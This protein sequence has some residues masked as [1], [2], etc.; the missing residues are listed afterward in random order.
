MRS[1]PTPYDTFAYLG[2]YLDNPVPYE[3][4]TPLIFEWLLRAFAALPGPVSWQEFWKS[5]GAKAN[6]FVHE[7]DNDPALDGRWAAWEEP[8]E[9]VYSILLHRYAGRLAGLGALGFA[10]A[11]PGRTVVL[12]TPIGDWLFGRAEEWKLPEIRKGVAVVGADFTVSLLEKSP[13]AEAELAGFA[14]AD[15]T[16]YRITRESVQAAA[17]AGRAAASMLETL[18][19]I[20]KHALPANV[21]HEIREWA[22]AKKT[23]R[24]EDTLLIEGDDPVVLAEIRGAFPK[25]FAPVGTAALR[26]LGKGNRESVM[27]R[28]AKKGFFSG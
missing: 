17:H 4:T 14:E 20:S 18:E 23:V 21:A 7:A 16:V 26:Y 3:A 22:R 1:R 5:A 9:K 11:G 8:P 2:D 28:L 13:E 12:P 19:G 25:D 6:P 24:I 10:E 15:G 27:R